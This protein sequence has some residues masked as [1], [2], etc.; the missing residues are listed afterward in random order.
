MTIQSIYNNPASTF[1]IDNQ[2]LW[3]VRFKYDLH[4]VKQV[5]INLRWKQLTSFCQLS[6][7]SIDHL[8]RS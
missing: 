4:R 8:F 2:K 1:T 5:F 7:D 6:F 3:R